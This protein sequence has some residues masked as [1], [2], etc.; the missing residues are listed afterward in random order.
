[1][2]ELEAE[3]VAGE[4]VVC[5]LR[6][7]LADLQRSL[8]QLEG[9]REVMLAASHSTHEQHSTSIEKLENVRY[10]IFLDFAPRIL[11][12]LGFPFVW[13]PFWPK[14][15]FSFSGRK[16]WTIVRHFDQIYFHAHNSLNF[17]VC[18]SLTTGAV[19]GEAREG[20]AT[21]TV[22]PRD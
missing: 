12:L 2:G 3:R 19:Q 14:S 17:C 9:E 15:K 21:H 16:P 7:Q 22:C 5:E 6:S 1:M 18:D 13:H 4:G 11:L 20:A 8:A 10:A